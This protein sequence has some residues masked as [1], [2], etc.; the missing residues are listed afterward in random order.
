MGTNPM[1]SYDE[2]RDF[3]VTITT[4]KWVITVDVRVVSVNLSC[5]F[6][7]SAREMEGLHH[8]KT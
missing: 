7:S 6:P 4:L 3:Y 2:E 8:E 1:I 5:L